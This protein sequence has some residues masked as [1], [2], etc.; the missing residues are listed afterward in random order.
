VTSGARAAG[1]GAGAALLV[2]QL[3]QTAAL[4]GAL[5]FLS[6]YELPEAVPLSPLQAVQSQRD[7]PKMVRPRRMNGMSYASEQEALRAYIAHLD[8]V[9]ELPVLLGGGVE[10]EEFKRVWLETRACRSL[11]CAALDTYAALAR[12]TGRRVLARPRWDTAGDASRRSVAVYVE[13]VHRRLRHALTA[14]DHLELLP[15]DEL[16]QAAR[17]CSRL[18]CEALDAYLEAARPGFDAA[19][20]APPPL[21]RG[22][23]SGEGP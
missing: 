20:E 13:D 23:T 8:G 15:P 19:G 16:M 18:R 1:R 4:V 22:P 12:A 2:A 10:L 5:V 9:F 7:Q 11:D 17:G 21:P 3:L 6:R 14:A